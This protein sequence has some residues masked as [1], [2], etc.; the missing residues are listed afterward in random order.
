MVES[1]AG[2]L[3]FF[4]AAQHALRIGGKNPCG[5]FVTILCRGL[6][7]YISRSDEDRARAILRLHVVEDHN[8][9]SSAQ[10]RRIASLIGEVAPCLSW[11]GSQDA[12]KSSKAVASWPKKSAACRSFSA[13]SSSRIACT[14]SRTTNMFSASA[15]RNAKSSAKR[16]LDR[17]VRPH[18]R[19][20]IMR[21]KYAYV[22][23]LTVAAWAVLAAPTLCLGGELVH[24]CV[25][26]ESDGCQ[27]EASCFDDP[28]LPLLV[29]SGTNLDAGQVPVDGAGPNPGPFEFSTQQLAAPVQVPSRPNHNL[30]IAPSDRPFL[31]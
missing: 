19:M 22:T 14:E 30:A 16:L 18:Y 17:P 24:P 8:K 21:L 4:A 29:R 7:S 25:P 31:I 28:C 6:W 2:R 1:R 23:P 12:T 5:V 9:G 15:V 27:H 3:R 10:R 26:H 11:P 13:S 20:P